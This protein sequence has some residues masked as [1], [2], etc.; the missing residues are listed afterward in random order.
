M[1]KAE[2]ARVLEEIAAMLELK[3]ENPFK[4]RAYT[5]AARALE[6]FTGDLVQMA[7]EDRLESVLPAAFPDRFG[8]RQAAWDVQDSFA[9]RKRSNYAR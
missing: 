9:R 7:R 8:E 2:V 6:T 4:I 1:D 5:N 3:G